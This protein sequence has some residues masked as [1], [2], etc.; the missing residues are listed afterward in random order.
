MKELFRTSLAV[1]G[2]VVGV[3]L[4]LTLPTMQLWN[5]V[6]PTVFGLPEISVW[7]ALALLILSQIFFKNSSSSN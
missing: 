1:I 3:V 6:M 5:Y 7:Q 2:V 4:L